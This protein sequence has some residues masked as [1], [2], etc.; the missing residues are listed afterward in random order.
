MLLVND[1]VQHAH[2][3]NTFHASSPVKINVAV[4]FDTLTVVPVSIGAIVCRVKLIVHVVRLFA[5]SFT[6][7]WSTNG[8][9]V[10]ALTTG[11]CVVAVVNVTVQVPDNFVRVY[12]EIPATSPFTVIFIVV[13]VFVI[14]SAGMVSRGAVLSILYVCAPVFTLPALSRTHAYTYHVPSTLNTGT[15]VDHPLQY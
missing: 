11:S 15:V 4:V 12:H 7:T 3:Y 1:P 6:T 2:E 14:I 8:Q 10:F 5:L 9:S 13:P